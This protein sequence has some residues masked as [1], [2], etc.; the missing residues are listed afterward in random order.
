MA[1]RSA[2]ALVE[3]MVALALLLGG[4]MTLA[5]LA[6]VATDSNRVSRTDSVSMILAAQKMEQLL[7]LAW[8]YDTSGAER[9]DL[10]TDVSRWPEADGGTGL[11]ASPDGTLAADVNGFAD[12]LD[13]NGRWL[14]AGG[15]PP[16]GAAFVRRWSIQP[17]ADSPAD[18]LVFRVVVVPRPSGPA[19]ACR[20][21]TD[22]AILT[23]VR[24]RRGP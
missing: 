1:N 5:G 8:G 9:I 19:D 15:S 7:G 10:Q 17:V 20:L 24:S 4:V 2:F 12:Y 23:R 21:R 13:E 11:A 6:S 3:V 18:A 14:A 22:G 16:P